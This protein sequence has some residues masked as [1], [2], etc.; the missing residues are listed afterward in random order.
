MA[1]IDPMSFN[2]RAQLV[3]L[4]LD[5]VRD[6]ARV[7]RDA[8]DIETATACGREATLLLESI[9]DIRAEQLE[10]HLR[11]YKG[12]RTPTVKPR[13]RAALYV[14]AAWAATLAGGFLLGRAL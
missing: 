5:R 13:W 2:T 11:G 7:A 6:R 14:V 12:P 8:G 3:L 10:A 1:D 4:Q 9:R